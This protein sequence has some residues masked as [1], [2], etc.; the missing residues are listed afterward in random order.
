M[1]LFDFLFGD[2]KSTESL[3]VTKSKS[4]L[5]G[6]YEYLKKKTEKLQAENKVWEIEINHTVLSRQ[7]AQKLEKENKLD[8]ALSVYLQSIERDENSKKLTICNFAFDID[9]VIV[10]YGK[11]KREIKNIFRGKNQ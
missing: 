5:L 1:G 4:D 10:L 2:K 3:K 9:R 8:E 6:E 7:K 11:T